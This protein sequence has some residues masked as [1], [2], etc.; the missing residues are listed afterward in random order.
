MNV[1]EKIRNFIGRFTKGKTF[2]D[3]DNIFETGLV[4]SLFAMQLV[5]Y[6]ETEFNVSIDN[7]DLDLENFKNV[8]S[9]VNLIEKKRSM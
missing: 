2:T 8:D 5:Q 6:I 7:S 3:S 1:N 4:N 9:I